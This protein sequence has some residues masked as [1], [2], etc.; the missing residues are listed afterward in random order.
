LEDAAHD[1][2]ELWENSTKVQRYSGD[3]LEVDILQKLKF[4]NES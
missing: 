3:E 4:D 2:E 1:A